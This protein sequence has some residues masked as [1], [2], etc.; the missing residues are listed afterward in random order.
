MINLKSI[1]LGKKL[2]GVF[3]LITILLIILSLTNI[4]TLGTVDSETKSLLENEVTLKE[5]AYEINSQMLQARRSEKDFLVRLDASYIDKVTAA[6]AE[7]KKNAG[8]IKNLDVLP[9]RKEMADKVIVLI[10]EYE[11]PFLE[12][13][14]LTKTKGLDENSGL[15]GELLTAAR[16]VENEIKKQNDDGLMAGMLELRRDEK[17]YILRGGADNQK[18]L[19]DN[20]KILRDRIAA[21][22]LSQNAKD[23]IN[24]KLLVY[25]STFDKLVNIDSQIISK[26]AEFTNKVHEIEPIVAEFITDA[27]ADESVVRAETQKMSS[28]A[29]AT[30][31]VL[32][33]ITIITCLAIGI[34]ASRSVTK[35]VDT[36]LYASRKV[37]DVALELSASSEEMKAATE[38]ISN[39]SQDISQG[40]SQQA[41]K[42]AEISRAMKEMSESIQQVSANSQK[43]AEGADAADKTAQEVGGMSKEV[44]KRMTEIQMTVDTSSRVIKELDTKSQKI[45]EIIGVITA[46]ADQTNLLALNAAI[47]AARAG[48]HGRGFAVVA[49]EVR[50]LA[51]E[52]RSA[53][54]TI[55][56][57]IKE[58][59]H[60]TKQAVESMDKGTRTVTEGAGTVET[61]VTAIDR[62]VKAAAE[63]A[64]MVQEIAAASEEQSVSVEEISATVEDVSTISEESAA[65]TQE[66][67]A[68]AEEQTSSMEELVMSA[69][70]LAE[71]SDKLQEDVVKLKGRSK[72][73]TSGQIQRDEEKPAVQEIKKMEMVEKKPAEMGGKPAKPE[74]K[75]KGKKKQIEKNHVKNCWEF[76][77]CG[78][79][80]GGSKAGELGICPSYP[81][82]GK[83][84]WKVAG[85]FCGGKVQGTQAQKHDTCLVCDWYKI[86]KT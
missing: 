10:G 14:Q 50:K 68:A 16:D 26:K 75:T 72:S 15:Q 41:S 43:A 86:V 28:T 53:A 48:D 40:V 19:H 23:T 39:T 17:N 61:A 71:L 22:K 37:A 79:E 42:M 35:P 3:G 60:G 63:V 85:T 13:A 52:S 44:L 66:A 1:S 69:Q 77:K 32:S 11:K 27:I 58:I 78:R 57:L 36:M 84:C 82:K 83:E 70:K 65:A 51:E 34:Y 45:G 55:T 21:S 31:T 25:V 47:E 54:G 29:K 56:E 67:S 59:Q 74:E 9:E 46:I 8:D 24:N 4:T 12:V 81:E 7:V 38:Q 6:T 49:D 2:V 5:K 30:V 80:K 20:E 18:I 33:L 64:T 73:D 76:M 62:I